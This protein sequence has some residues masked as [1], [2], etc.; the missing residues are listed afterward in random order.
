MALKHSTT[1][2]TAK[3]ASKAELG[4]RVGSVTEVTRSRHIRESVRWMLWGKAAGR[5]EF[6]GCNRLLW[7]SPVTQEKVNIAEA[8]HIYAFSTDGPR[9]NE[10]I[11]EEQL[12]QLDNL[13][14]A[15][16]D[17][18]KTMD[19]DGVGDR[20]SVEL[21]RQWKSE[22]ERRIEIV[23]GVDPKKQS[24]VVLF[25]A[26]IGEHS[27]PLNFAEAAYAL[28]PDWYP[29][30]DRPIALE[31]IDGIEKDSAEDYWKTQRTNLITKFR[32]RVKERIERGEI[33]HISVFALA[34]QPL[35][36]LLG[37]LMI[38]ITRAEV[39][40]RHREP[41]ATW[42][43]PSAYAAC[44]FQ[45]SEPRSFKGPPALVLA[46]SAPVND[47]RITSA[48]PGA[49]IWKVSVTR[50][51]T[52]LI[53]SRQHLSAFRTLIRDL[54]DRINSRHGQT[55]TLHVFP[56][57]GV[58]LAVEFGRVRMPKAHAP[59]VIYDQNNQ[60]GGFVPILDIGKG[61]ES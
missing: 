52:D 59:W 57:A 26:G 55:T 8:A 32:L 39:Y 20:Y 10:G 40:Q 49:A 4:E 3:K 58:S 34:P 31:I 30:E 25:G 13:M 7:K 28:F 16:H 5:C 60:L 41:T 9:G 42:S 23:T 54:L 36:I 27:K 12:N 38:D 15:C 24:H 46:L 56:V 17:C 14:L 19:N 44:D 53:K 22:H 29:A 51:N 6:S 50:P 2:N 48:L 37:T 33:E 45:V 35:L 47:E 61:E 43:W 1:T 11:D 18:H 21:L